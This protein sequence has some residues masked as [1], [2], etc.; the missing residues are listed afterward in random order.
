MATD[1]NSQPTDI[2][3][4]AL[5]TAYDQWLELQVQERYIV[6]Q[7]SRLRQTFLA[8]FPLAY[9]DGNAPDLSSMSLAD[10]I[11]MVIGGIDRPVNAI[12]M[13]GKLLDIG[14]DLSKYDNPLANIHTAMNRMV[15]A[16][17]MTWADDEEKKALPG[18]ELKS[19]PAPEQKPSD[20]PLR[21]SLLELLTSLDIA[22]EKK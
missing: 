3:K 22:G 1:N 5:Q 14:F 18:P 6:M 10:A 19:V 8:L 21:N 4:D 9:P 11:R 13:R 15:E 7:K 20:D 16:E 2:Y 17:E 12:E